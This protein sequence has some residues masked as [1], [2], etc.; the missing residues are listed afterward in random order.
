MIVPD[1]NSNWNEW[2]ARLLSL[3]KSMY[4]FY[5][6]DTMIHNAEEHDREHVIDRTMAVAFT[7]C[8]PRLMIMIMLM[9][10]M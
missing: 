3:A 7:I 8:F 4:T 10:D 9:A 2:P 1:G 5:G 6:N